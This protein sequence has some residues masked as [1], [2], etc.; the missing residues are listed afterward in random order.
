M[1]AR[2][3]AVYMMDDQKTMDNFLSTINAD[4]MDYLKKGIVN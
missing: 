1:D 2:N 3:R 4:E